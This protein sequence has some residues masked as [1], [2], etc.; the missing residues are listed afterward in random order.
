MSLHPDQWF[1]LIQREKAPLAVFLLLAAAALIVRLAAPF[2]FP[3]PWNDETAFIAQGYALA[4]QGTLFVDALHPERPI[5]WMPPG[6]PLLL[7][8]VF[9]VFGYSFDVARGVSTFFYLFSAGLAL[10]LVRQLPLSIWPRRLAMGLTA[11]AFLSPYSLAMSNIARMEAFCYSLYLLSLLLMIRG[12]PGL[13]L[14]IVLCSA[15]VHFNA[16]Y[17]LLPYALLLVWIIGRR[18]QLILTAGELLALLLS[19]AAL[20]AYALLVA[21]QL[22]GFIEDMRFQFEFKRMGPPLGGPRGWWALGL[23]LA[24]AALQSWRSGRFGADTILSLHAAAFLALALHGYSMWY[25]FTAVMG[26]WLLLL[27]LLTTLSNCSPRWPHRAFYAV[28]IAGLLWPFSTHGFSKIEHFAPLWPRSELLSRDFLAPNE[29]QR[30]RSWLAELPEGTRV[31]FG[32]TGIEP[33]FLDDAQRA[34]VIW[35]A[36]R[37]SMTQMLPVRRDD[38]RVTCDSSLYPHYAFIFDWDINPPRRGLDSG[39]RIGP[40]AQLPPATQDPD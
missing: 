28:L 3:I 30:I 4:T 40:P 24:L 6:Y 17:L 22:P 14:A 16:I 7:A 5:M 29:I 35:S 38:Y 32:Y 36:T 2:E 1:T 12:R 9:T 34:G 13:G 23:I 19:F 18:E 21:T 20:A 25:Q 31:S 11:I 37:Q 10:I 27:A 15:V 8:G 33:F 26:C 39:C